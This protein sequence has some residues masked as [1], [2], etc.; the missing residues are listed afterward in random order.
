M[1]LT[2]KLDGLKLKTFKV[3]SSTKHPI[4]QKINSFEIWSFILSIGGRW[5][6]DL[7]FIF[8]ATYIFK[9]SIGFCQGTLEGFICNPFDVSLT[10]PKGK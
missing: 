6:E 9:I 2:K 3:K 1:N 4:L 7:E 5:W 8:A 10:V